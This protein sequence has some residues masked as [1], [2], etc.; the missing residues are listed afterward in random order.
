MGQTKERGRPGDA[1]ATSEG[2]LVGFYDSES[3]TK[4]PFTQEASLEAFKRR[5][6]ALETVADWKDDFNARV[7]RAQL[8]FELIGFD[9]DEQRALYAE[10]QALKR[11]GRALTW[12]GRAST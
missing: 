3:N 12:S 5:V 7:T 10:G 8:R 6:V 1:V 9:I 11:V 4:R 2:R